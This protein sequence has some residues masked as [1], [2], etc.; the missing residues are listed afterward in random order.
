MASQVMFDRKWK[1][2]LNVSEEVDGELKVTKSKTI[3]GLKVTFDIC[4]T[5]L[6]DPS[7][8]TFRIYNINK[9]TE[10]FLTNNNCV[11]EFYSG[12]NT[13]LE[14]AWNLL[15]SGE[16][17]NSYELRQQ[18]NSV[19]N[20]WARNGFT[21]LNYKKVTLAPVQNPISPH[22]ILG[23]L[24]DDSLFL[25]SSISYVNGCEEILLEA[26]ELD[27]FSVTG[28]LQQELNDLLIPLG[29][30]WQI[31]GNKLIV[32]DG[33]STK[34]GTNENAI[35]INDKTGLLSIPI[36]DYTGVKFTS[37]LN[38]QLQVTKIVEIEPNTARYDLGN[39]FYV[40]K[41]DKTKWSAAGK[42]RIFE[43]THRGDTRGDKWTSEVTAFYNRS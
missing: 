19:W 12:Y 35:K 39:E 25:N 6:G 27:E 24:V 33:V 1:I 18:T 22:T 8:G 11:I 30:G 28:S 32:F 4:N 13:D 41:F 40:K 34:P 16:I 14:D 31:I 17:T 15:F 5:L 26:E 2:V 10:N 3:T 37:L 7:L 38:G 20:I 42:F 9:E 21:A 36:V 29:L 23:R 43:V